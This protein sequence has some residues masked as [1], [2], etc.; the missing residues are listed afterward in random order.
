MAVGLVKETAPAA[1]APAHPG[2]ER[3]YYA[4]SGAGRRALA[5]EADRLKRAA[6][7]ASRRLRPATGRS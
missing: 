3:R 4:L 2:L 7:V 6:A 5:D 1:D